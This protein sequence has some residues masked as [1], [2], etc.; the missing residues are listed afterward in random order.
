M[1][2]LDVTSADPVRLRGPRTP[3]EAARLQT[4]A[5]DGPPPEVA[6]ADEHVV[7]ASAETEMAAAF[8]PFSL[9]FFLEEFLR[10]S[11]RSLSLSEPLR[12]NRT[13]DFAVDGEE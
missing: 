3:A 8:P 9:S 13:S 2:L 6:T 1:L 11:R 7:A 10:T 4:S 12:F 5:G